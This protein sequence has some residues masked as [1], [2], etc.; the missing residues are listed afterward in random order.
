[1]DSLARVVV[2]AVESFWRAKR[3]APSWRG[4]LEMLRSRACRE[5]GS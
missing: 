4:E 2:C 5:G 1:M 3:E